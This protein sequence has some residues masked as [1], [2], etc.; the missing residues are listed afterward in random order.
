L[1]ISSYENY[2]LPTQEDYDSNRDVEK[3][4]VSIQNI[5]KFLEAKRDDQLNFLV[6]DACRNNPFGNRSR[7]GV[8]S[9]GLAKISTPSG[10]LI[11]FSTDPG[12][13]APDGDGD[14]SVYTNSLSKN[15][16]QPNIPIEQVFKNVYTDVWNESNNL[17]SPVYE[18]KLSGE[19]FILKPDYEPDYE[20]EFYDGEFFLP[21]PD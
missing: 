1:Y 17:Q 4:G 21:V 9:N 20:S 13:T 12:E 2:L 3:N 15:L 19:E 16:L 18:S 10:S 6:L 5:M 7:S 11:V 14:N 8:N